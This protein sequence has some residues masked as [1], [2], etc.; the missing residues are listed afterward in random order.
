MSAP[1]HAVPFYPFA[2]LEPP[3][4]AKCCYVLMALHTNTHTFARTLCQSL[5]A[6]VKIM[7][8]QNKK[9]IESQTPAETKEIVTYFARCC[10]SALHLWQ[11]LSTVFVSLFPS[12]FHLQHFVSQFNKRSI[13]QTLCVSVVLSII[14][15]V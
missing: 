4:F 1:T 3:D 11:R 10:C 7:K 9:W 6:V 14:Y 12:L 8:L 15:A 2:P 5:G 13:G